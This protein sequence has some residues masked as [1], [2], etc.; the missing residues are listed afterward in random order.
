MSDLSV[1]A[2][3][4]GFRIE[5]TIGRGSMGTVYSAQDLALDR[6]VAVKV[7]AQG[8]ARDERFRERFLRESR[9]VAS[10]E[11]PNI[12]P[13]YAAGEADGLLYLAMRYVDGRDLSSL[14]EVLG[15]L[16]PERAVELVAQVG[17]ALDAAHA[18]GLIHRDVKPANI[19]LAHHDGRSD[20]AYLCDFGLAKH[21]STVSSLSGD[22]GIVGTVEYLAPEQ[23]EGGPVDARVD[24]YA[25]GCVLY[26]LLTGESPFSRGNELGA[27][28]AHINDPPPKLSERRPELP[29]A[30][31]DVIATALAK[32]RDLRYPTCAAMVEAARAALR[33]ERAGGR[34]AAVREA[35]AVRTFL[36]AD[37]RGYTSYTREHGDEAAAALAQAFAAARVGARAAAP[38]D[39]AGAPR[40]RGARRLR[41]RARRPALRARAPGRGRGY[42]GSHGRS[43]SAWTR[44]RRSPSRTASAAAPSTGPP[45][46]AL[47][48]ARARCSRRDAVRELAGI[49]R[50]RRVRLPAGRAAQ[51]LR[52]AGRRRRDPRDA[53]RAGARAAAERR[54]HACWA[55]A[56]GCGSA[57]SRQRSS[58]RRPSSLLLVVGR[59]SSHAS[60]LP[61]GSLGI[62]DAGTGKI[63]GSFNPGSSEV[64]ALIAD[65]G[66]FWAFSGSNG[67][68]LQQID[69]RRRSR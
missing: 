26:E 6:R 19:L 55:R 42:A 25:L 7:L 17:N 66:G 53:R 61:A 32:D 23:I 47:S 9:L 57:C 43:A 64:D 28:L 29:E 40:R 21:A 14:L 67:F 12:V 52:E 1:G 49:D 33:G 8:L 58:Q 63:A 48:P 27:L 18:R 46:C 30:M 62:V 37:V 68:F 5:S 22:R 13:I 65:G 41:L 56:R 31:D 3:L 35:G 59:G 16:D 50:R 4:A 54:A 24:V 44:A 51:G 60:A 15:R 34:A 69:T 45:G 39:A 2:A 36:F 10:L 11:H 38:G 20:H